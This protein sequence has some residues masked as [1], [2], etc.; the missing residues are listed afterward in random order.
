MISL[1]AQDTCELSVTWHQNVP[2]FPIALITP[3]FPTWLVFYLSVCC[4]SIVGLTIESNPFI[5]TRNVWLSTIKVIFR[6]IHFKS[7]KVNYA[8]TGCVW[9]FQR[10]P[11]VHIESVMY[12]MQY[13]AHCMPLILSCW[14][15]I[16]DIRNPSTLILSS[17]IMYRYVLWQMTEV[18][19][20][21]THQHSTGGGGGYF[22]LN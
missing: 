19:S 17:E 16:S 9:S 18:L 3:T 14:K 1:V 21:G 5:I 7:Q 15:I 11:I 8:S 22:M 20:D 13:P 10:I 6:S 2:R 4:T 12:I